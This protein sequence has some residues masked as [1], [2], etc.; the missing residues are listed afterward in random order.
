M[1]K[2]GRKGVKGPSKP[3]TGEKPAASESAAFVGNI[4]T[5]LISPLLGNVRTYIIT[6]TVAG[7]FAAGSYLAIA[8]WHKADKL[9][10][11]Y[12][13]VAISTQLADEN[14]AFYSNVSKALEKM[15]KL[16]V[17]EIS[18]GTFV[19]SAENPSYQLFLYVPAEKDYTAVLY[20][21][22]NDGWPKC[23]HV[24]VGSREIVPLNLTKRKLD[25]AEILP[26]ASAGT[27]ENPENS[28]YASDSES[29]QLSKLHGITFQL[30]AQAPEELIAAA[31]KN[32]PCSLVPQQLRISYVTLVAPA[33]RM[34]Q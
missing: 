31:A 2:R 14:S 15:R 10:Q 23:H 11:N 28:K 5:T 30:K 6:G 21:D 9:I 13:A 24:D 4:K 22:G 12:V 34:G 18:A 29:G 3:M 1:P 8:G 20:Y 19:L 16:E 32:D 7:I 27:P 17:G 26:S 25:L 33:I